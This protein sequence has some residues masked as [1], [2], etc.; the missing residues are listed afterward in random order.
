MFVGVSTEHAVS[1][2]TGDTFVLV[3]TEGEAEFL[4]SSL[5][6]DD[7]GD[8]VY[9]SD[10]QTIKTAAGSNPVKVGRMTQRLS[11]TRARVKFI[12]GV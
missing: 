5:A 3:R 1:G 4:G 8:V 10:D 11:A 7:V 6:A 2:A 12:H 9:I